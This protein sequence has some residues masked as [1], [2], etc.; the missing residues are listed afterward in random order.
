MVYFTHIF[1]PFL[2]ATLPGGGLSPAALEQKLVY[3]SWQRAADAAKSRGIEV[4]F[5]GVTVSS[6]SGAVPSF[7]RLSS[8]LEHYATD[9]RGAVL[10]TIGK[11]RD[12]LLSCHH[13]FMSP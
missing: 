7:A 6:D 2:A 4:E 9:A 8:P 3:S 12:V 1:A 10:P 5:L 13:F 11:P